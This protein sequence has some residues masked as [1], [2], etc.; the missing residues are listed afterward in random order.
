MHIKV[1]E[2]STQMPLNFYVDLLP[3]FIFVPLLAI[4]EN[5]YFPS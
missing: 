5:I 1:L 2:N 3:S 4:S